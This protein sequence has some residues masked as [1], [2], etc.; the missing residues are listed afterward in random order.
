MSAFGSLESPRTYILV[1]SDFTRVDEA[2][3]E[4]VHQGAV[5]LRPE[6]DQGRVVGYNKLC[7]ETLSVEWREK[8]ADAGLVVTCFK[9]M[10]A[11]EQ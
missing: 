7:T 10:G 5:V 4:I 2:Y 1:P 3:S 11:T 6:G 9:C 8:P